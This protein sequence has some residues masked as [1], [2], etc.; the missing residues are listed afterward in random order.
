MIVFV[1]LY[2]FILLNI[3]DTNIKM[4]LL[5]GLRIVLI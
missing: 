3:Q 5:I 1:F 4:K 2:W